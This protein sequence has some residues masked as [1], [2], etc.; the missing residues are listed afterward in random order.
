MHPFEMVHAQSS[1]GLVHLKAFLGGPSSI[2][3][4][5]RG[6]LGRVNRKHLG[7]VR[8]SEHGKSGVVAVNDARVVEQKMGVG[9][10]L[11]QQPEFLNGGGMFH[12]SAAHLQQS[13][14]L[15]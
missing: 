3:L 7:L 13:H 12:E 5:L 4:E 2:G 10:T 6:E 15:P 11:E 14:Y 9:G 8:A 1:R